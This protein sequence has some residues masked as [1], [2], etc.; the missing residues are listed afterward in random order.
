MGN[1]LNSY[2]EPGIP[3]LGLGRPKRRFE[4]KPRRTVE[5][6]FVRKGENRK[7]RRMTANR[8]FRDPR[9]VRQI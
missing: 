9:N 6:M 7:S 1:G 3:G 5:T 2:P 4:S 8:S